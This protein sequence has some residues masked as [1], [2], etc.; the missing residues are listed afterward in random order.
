[1]AIIDLKKGSLKVG[2][3]IKFK[4]GDNE[5]TQEISSL[6]IEHKEVE[7]VKAGDAFGLK[8]DQPTK[9]GTEVYSV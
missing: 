8:V 2:G 5:F 7:E 3:K 6:Q 9:P 1:V 4:H